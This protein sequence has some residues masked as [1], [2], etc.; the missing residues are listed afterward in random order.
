[1]DRSRLKQFDWMLLLSTLLLVGFG[2]AALYSATS[3]WGPSLF[4]RQVMWLVLAIAL[5]IPLIFINPLT[6]FKY[7]RVIYWLNVL[8][9]LAVDFIGEERKGAQRWIVL[10]GGYQ[11]QP[12]EFAK[13]MLILSLAAML[14]RLGEDI[15]TVRGFLRTALYVALPAALVFKQPDL[16]TSIVLM[17]IW[18]TMIYMANAQPK[19]MAITALLGIF[20]FGA[21][22]QFDILKPYQK[23]RLIAFMNP[24]AHEKEGGYQLIQSRLA[25]GNG[26]LTGKG[27]LHG[28]QKK[29]R[30]IPEQQTDFIFSVIAEEGGFV[31]SLT[32]L[33]LFSFFLV[34]VWRVMVGTRELYFR[35]IAAGILIF[36][37]FHL[38]TN[39][40]MVM[41]LFPV[42]GIPL[43]FI[44]LGGSML[45]VCVMS[46][47]L[48]LGIS[49][50]GESLR[51]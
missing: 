45:L 32:M 42:V 7:A 28:E 51:F 5:T 4:K 46:V 21:M 20:A 14:T 9:L 10:P 48:L 1:M 39:L 12:S 50:R 17:V 43:P 31:G 16:G 23:E 13:L 40:A 19:H 41:S 6:W 3:G 34:R 24:E 38:F 25:I 36:F 27:Y 35:Y 33:G 18:F 49:L 47:G 15:K 37:T 22:W 8:M 30:Y 2:M 44:S 26:Q 29:L 11:L